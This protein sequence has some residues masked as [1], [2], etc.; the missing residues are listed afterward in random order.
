[1]LSSSVVVTER[2][3]S[4]RSSRADVVDTLPGVLRVRGHPYL[5]GIA[6]WPSR[7][8]TAIRIFDPGHSEIYGDPVRSHCRGR[9]DVRGSGDSMVEAT[10]RRRRPTGRACTRSTRDTLRESLITT[11]NIRRAC[12]TTFRSR[13]RCRTLRSRWTCSTPAS[14]CLRWRIWSSSGRSTR[15][16]SS[17]K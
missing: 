12:S 8:V 15:R 11:R 3:R 2:S 5:H 1:M 13:T 4:P 6:A 10:R 14:T 9:T 17:G 16:S 7:P